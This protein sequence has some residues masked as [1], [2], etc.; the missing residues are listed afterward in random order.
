RLGIAL[1]L[2]E[3]L[4]RTLDRFQDVLLI[5]RE[6]IPRRVLHVALPPQEKGLAVLDRF[7]RSRLDLR[8][9]ADAFLGGG[10]REIDE[11]TEHLL[12]CVGPQGKYLDG[13][14]RELGKELGRLRG[15]CH[16]L[17]LLF[18]VADSW[19]RARDVMGRI[20]TH[21]ANAVKEFTAVRYRAH[22][23]VEPSTELNR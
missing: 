8:V 9:E 5:A 1:Q 4:L 10:S 22:A 18:V 6:G 20:L 7:H 15:S 17:F 16:C 14:A 19:R 2:L 13:P 3:G 11:F 12:V 21:C 23:M